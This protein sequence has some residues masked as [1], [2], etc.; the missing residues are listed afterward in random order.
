MGGPCRQPCGIFYVSTGVLQT[1]GK[2]AARLHT[3]KAASLPMPVLCPITSVQTGGVWPRSKE[4]PSSHEPAADK[5]ASGAAPPDTRKPAG[6]P[7]ANI[8]HYEGLS[9]PSKEEEEARS[10]EFSGTLV[11]P[12]EPPEMRAASHGPPEGPPPGA[13]A[14]VLCPCPWSALHSMVWALEEESIVCRCARIA[15]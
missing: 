1:L 12:P 5:Q 15:V 7:K 9:P 8:P 3:C 10:L 11:Q 13:P 2:H 6:L 14:T 4:Q